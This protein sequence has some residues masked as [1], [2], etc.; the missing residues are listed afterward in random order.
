MAKI[1]F[2]FFL[3]LNAKKP[4]R[5]ISSFRLR[6][7]QVW[8]KRHNE[9]CRCSWTTRCLTS[10]T[11]WSIGRVS[12]PELERTRNRKYINFHTADSKRNS[13]RQCDFSKTLSDPFRHRKN[14]CSDSL[15]FAAL[16]N[17]L[18][19]SKCWPEYV[20][21][22]IVSKLLSFNCNCAHRDPFIMEFLK[23]RRTSCKRRGK[24]K[25]FLSGR[26]YNR[27]NCRILSCCKLVGCYIN[28]FSSSFQ[29]SFGR[30]DT[31]V[32]QT[33]RQIM[34]RMEQF[35]PTPIWAQPPGFSP[36]VN[37]V[38]EKQR[39]LDNAKRN[40]GIS[41]L[42]AYYVCTQ[43]LLK[44]LSLR[45]NLLAP[46]EA[47][48]ASLWQIVPISCKNPAEHGTPIW[49]PPRN[50][51]SPPRF[52]GHPRSQPRSAGSEWLWRGC[53]PFAFQ[54]AKTC[55]ST[56]VWT[57]TSWRQDRGWRD[58][59]PWTWLFESSLTM[60]ICKRNGYSMEV[61]KPHRLFLLGTQMAQWLLFCNYASQKYRRQK[62]R[63]WPRW[64][65]LTHFST[66]LVCVRRKFS[67]SAVEHDNWCSFAQNRGGNWGGKLRCG[68][69]TSWPR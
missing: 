43:A 48:E 41:G 58:L 15:S 38:A 60:S 32:S 67:S 21:A 36:P 6:R 9:S 18:I 49:V 46:T 45:H 40:N 42:R 59:D 35:P 47:C 68:A 13:Q 23:L 37:P 50:K 62:Y 25:L 12:S 8:F 57:T 54:K 10:R 22:N 44:S 56:C 27:K 2:C 39:L 53:F 64:C 66:L 3:F 7:V 24:K 11:T 31:T 5:A 28:D 55:A 17:T 29:V 16:E 65:R 30:C 69:A 19:W 20:D 34:Q 63:L 4:C 26:K 1:K 14:F 52:P 33:E 61:T 51:P